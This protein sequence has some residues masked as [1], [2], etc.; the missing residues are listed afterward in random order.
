MEE[1]DR[2][3]SYLRGELD[4][5]SLTEFESRMASEPSFRAKVELRRLL[6]QSIHSAYEDN[7]RSKLKEF[8]QK[9]DRVTKRIKTRYMIAASLAL[10]VA[11]VFGVYLYQYGNKAKFEK[12]DVY[13]N[14]IPNTMGSSDDT[15][16]AE[17]MNHFKVSQYSDALGLFERISQ[18]DTVLY[19]SGVSAYRTGDLSKAIRCFQSIE[20]GSEYYRKANYRLGLTY[21]RNNQIDLAIPVLMKAS[22]D[23]ANDYSENAKEILSKEF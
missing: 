16:F 13:E 9:M 15:K 4:Q 5:E 7:L 21:W 22:Q 2:I 14:G 8:D 3:D 12:Y 19:Y 23:T 11:T 18:S 1:S 6:I 10:M 17:A 20:Q